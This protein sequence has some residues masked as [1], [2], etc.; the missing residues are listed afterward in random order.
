M[1]AEANSNVGAYWG[2]TVCWDVTNVYITS[3]VSGVIKYNTGCTHS[4]GL[5]TDEIQLSCNNSDKKKLLAV[6]SITVCLFIHQ[7]NSYYLKYII[8]KGKAIRSLWNCTPTA[9]QLYTNCTP[10]THQPHTNCTPISHQLHTNRTP[11]AHQSHTNCTP[12]A[13]QLH[14]NCT[15]TTHQLHTN[16]TPIAHQWHTNYTPIAHQLHTNYTPIA[17]QLHTAQSFLRNY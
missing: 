8:W 7:Q 3:L 9:H 10:T 6:P 13:H 15:P 11:T 14:T 17:H 2:D 16:Y 12:I 4:N 5:M 1:N